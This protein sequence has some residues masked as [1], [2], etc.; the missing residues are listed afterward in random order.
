MRR[1]AFLIY[2]E[3][4]ILDI[5]GP[6]TAFEIASRLEPESY[7]LQLI[8]L[9]PGAVASSSGFAMHA[10]GLLRAD[11]IDT[12][13]ITGGNG[14]REAA[15]CEKTLRFVTAC[16]TKCRRIASVCSG[17]YLLAAA[18]LLD[19]KRATTHWS[20]TRDLQAKFPDVCLDADRIYIKSGKVW[21][22]AGITA[23]IDLALALISEDLGERVS[24]RVAQQMVVYHRRPGGQSQFS[25]L[26]ELEPSDDR[27]ANVLE[28]M[29]AN[30]RKPLAV[31]D[32]A[33]R[34]NMSP[35]HFA[36]E[37]RA[38]TG[39]TPAKAVERM[40]ADAARAALDSGKRSIQ[41]I[42]R[43]CGFGAPERM[44]RTFVRMFGGS[45]SGLRRRQAQ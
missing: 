38:A 13:L 7:S 18:R 33:S 30:L 17:T 22:S 32:L 39:I 29:R 27:F 31:A 16:H 6:I 44:R 3:F 37:F 9:E 20:R 35:R 43:T 8:A 24:R 28:H 21:T 23:G 14:S 34:A 25:P 42:A 2:P 5:T 11:S 10:T 45:P 12:L 41:D 40:R 26:L 1:I 19:G 36:R 4:Q 15:K